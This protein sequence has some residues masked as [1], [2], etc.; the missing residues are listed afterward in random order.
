MQLNVNEFVLTKLDPECGLAQ[1]QLVC[2][3]DQMTNNYEEET[4]ALISEFL[5]LMISNQMVI[6]YPNL[7]NTV[8]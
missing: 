1:P 4:Y 5:C 6:F 8:P 3:P 2:S 7:K